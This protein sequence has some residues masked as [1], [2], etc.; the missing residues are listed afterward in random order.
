MT[1]KTI[2]I[3]AIAGALLGACGGDDAG[4]PPAPGTPGSTFKAAPAAATATGSL[5]PRVHIEDRV[6]QSE[7]ATIRHVFKE[8]DFVA[9]TNRD[10][11]QSF[12]VMMPGTLQA[13]L[14]PSGVQVGAQ[15]TNPDQLVATNYSYAD[16][17]LVGIVAQ[18]TQR[19]VLM[20]DSGNYGHII[21]RG[22]CVGKEKAM[23]KDIG[24]GYLTFVVMPDSVPNA[25]QRPPEEHSL[26]LHPSDLPL[27]EYSL[28]REEPKE[29]QPVMPPT[30]PVTAPSKAL[31]L[32]APVPER[33]GVP[34]SG[35]PPVKT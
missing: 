11:F 7:K 14:E 29:V 15:C 25:Q 9:D 31:P 3:V 1:R 16:L 22:D 27:S 30:S 18:G 5:I 26:Q 12:V 13:P 33:I 10:P 4:E 20:M 24:T 32:P 35:S 28:P 23:V 2:L 21:K 34:P 17:K 19:K 6:P 8:R